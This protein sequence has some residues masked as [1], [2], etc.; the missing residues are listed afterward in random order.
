MAVSEL[1]SGI[2]T[3]AVRHPVAKQ[4]PTPDSSASLRLAGYQG[5]WVGRDCSLAVCRCSPPGAIPEHPRAVVFGTIPVLFEPCLIRLLIK[6]FP[7]K[8]GPF[9][10]K[11]VLLNTF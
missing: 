11:T 6:V 10:T 5:A 8:I 3:N 7:N 4:D 2:D 1:L 9:A